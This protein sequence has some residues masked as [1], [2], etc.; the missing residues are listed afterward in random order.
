MHWG[1]P[2][3]SASFSEGV[4]T[5]PKPVS[6]P[7]GAP[8][9]PVA[10]L[11]TPRLVLRDWRDEDLEPFRALNLDREVRRYF[12]NVLMPY[13]SDAFAKSIREFLATNGWGLWA[14]EVVGGPSF[15]GFVGLGRPGF[16]PFTS[17]VELGWRLSRDAWGKG[18]ATEAAG[19]AAAHAFTALGLDELVAFTTTNNMPSRRVME[20][21]GMAHDHAGDFQH[22]RIAEGHPLRPHVLY[23][24]TFEA[25]QARRRAGDDAPRHG[26]PASARAPR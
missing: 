14:V 7:P 25:W 19:A 24:L 4:T 9:V 16:E 21:L 22:P 23:R 1:L 20:K 15:I 6:L 26:A 2:F 5:P 10:V 8:R 12:P 3:L 17:S 18:Y 13:E 11:H